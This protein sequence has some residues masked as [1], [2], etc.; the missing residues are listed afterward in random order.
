MNL[1][2]FPFRQDSG[3][4]LLGLNSAG[5]PWITWATG[6]HGT[7]SYGAA[8]VPNNAAT[9]D[10]S[11]GGHNEQSAE[12]LEPAAVYTKSA[13]PTV[14][15][16]V[17]FGSGPGTDVLQGVVDSTAVFKVLRGEL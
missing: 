1:N 8:N 7:R 14:D 16:V 17:V 9:A 13:L 15:D 6:P 3:I 10:P 5:Q 2:G 11:F 12:N 4:A